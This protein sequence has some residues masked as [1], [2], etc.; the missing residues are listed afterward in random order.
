MSA[1]F[2]R[3]QEDIAKL[4]AWFH[5]FALDLEDGT[6]DDYKVLTTEALATVR[7]LEVD[8]AEADEQADR[9]EREGADARRITRGEPPT[10]ATAGSLSA[11]RG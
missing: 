9:E 7:S 2:S 8:I 1:R 5:R 4:Y 10:S 11:E 6:L 3:A